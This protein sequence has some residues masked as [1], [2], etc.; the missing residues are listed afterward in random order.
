MTRETFEH[1]QSS[2]VKDTN[3]DML[4]GNNCDIVINE[5]GNAKINK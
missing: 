3:I 5:S 4:I 2:E 1:V